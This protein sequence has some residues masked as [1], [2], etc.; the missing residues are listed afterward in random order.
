MA[1]LVA[2][3]MEQHGT[4]IIREAVPEKIERLPDNNKLLVHWLSESGQHKDIFDT[5][6]M[7]V[8]V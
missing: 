7:A 1:S 6:F 3:A 8:G 2:E 5:V 4:K